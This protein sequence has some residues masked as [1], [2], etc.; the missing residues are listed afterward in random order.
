LGAV[1][2]FHQGIRPELVLILTSVIL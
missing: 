2:D 1:F